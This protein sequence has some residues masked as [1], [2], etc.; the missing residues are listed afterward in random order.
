MVRN[1]YLIT[2]FCVVILSLQSCIHGDL[3]DCPPMVNYAVA[4][5][6]THH[7]L[8]NDRFYDDV[9][10]VNLFVFDDHNLVYTTVEKYSPYATNF[11]ISLNHLPMGNYHILAWGNV[12]DQQPFTI[13]PDSFKVGKT[14]LAEARLT[15]ERDSVNRSSQ[16]M[17]KLFFGEVDVEVPLYL[18]R[19][20]TIP[21][22]NDTKNVR[23]VIH[24]DHSG[25]LRATQSVINYE[26]VQLRINASNA[27]Y[28]FR[29]LFTGTD[30]VVYKP[31]DFRYNRSLLDINPRDSV[32]EQRVYHYSQDDIH[33][34][35]N[36][37]VYDFTILRMMTVS[38]I[39]LT[40]ERV[41]KIWPNSPIVIAEIDII[42]DFISLFDTKN[43]LPQYNRQ[44]EFDKYD[45]YRIDIYLTYDE[46]AG[47]Y[48][49]GVFR[50]LPW[51]LVDQPTI[52]GFNG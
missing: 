51:H 14:T 37:C 3:D 12:L 9:K 23:V 45:Q 19:I 5:K 30:N 36:V 47:E 17:E 48:V 21:L 40:V 2:A 33:E 13:S 11:N 44:S 7:A 18:S 10:V 42:Q 39:K 35:S 26:E 8:G 43:T 28:N 16:E 32:L 52:P 49:T 4:F 6:Y 25:E 38:P 34:I 29:N 20:D 24:W 22:I 50:T 41:K 1:K 31:F 27:V 46:I 15:L